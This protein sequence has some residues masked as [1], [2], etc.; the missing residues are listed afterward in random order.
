MAAFSKRSLAALSTCH[1]DLQKLMSEAIKDYD[2]AV[3]C[4]HRGRADQDRA[5]AQGMSKLAFPK[6][7]HN[8]LPSLAVDIVP[9]PVRWKD[10][11]SF[12]QLA[13]HIHKVADQLGIKIR[14][15]ADWN[16]NGDYT[17]EK[18]SDWPHYELVDVE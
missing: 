5:V 16:M 9:Y 1:P 2:F 17:D 6:S 14:H 4:G 7:K 18:F 15:G 11:D 13:V 3:I 12:K 8:K 10:I